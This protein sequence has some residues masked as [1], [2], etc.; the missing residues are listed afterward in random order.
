MFKIHV[1]VR[2]ITP[3][4]PSQINDETY[5]AKIPNEVKK[6]YDI[7]KISAWYKIAPKEAAEWEASVKA[8][9]DAQDRF[10][11]PHRVIWGSLLRAAGTK[12]LD[13]GR[14][15]KTSGAEVLVIG[16]NL[17]EN[18]A[19]LLDGKGKPARDYAV[20]TE[21][22]RRPARTGAYVKTA[23]P[24]FFPWGCN[25]T[26]LMDQGAGYQQFL[27]LVYYSVAV[28]GWCYGWGDRRPEK[29]KRTYG[30][31]EV[32]KFEFEGY[33]LPGWSPPEVSALRVFDEAGED[34]EKG[35]RGKKSDKKEAAGG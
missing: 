34:E 35:K 28:S 8:W 26:L 14:A 17:N 25:F 29:R 16:A 18:N 21:Y 22:V 11:V 27:D 15:R 2:G 31:F 5:G 23:W 19:L 30:R 4:S 32:T 13:I 10:C 1:G 24:V 9:R 7:E 20:E 33:K 6:K 3:L 12:R